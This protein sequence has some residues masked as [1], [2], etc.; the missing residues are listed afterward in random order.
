[1]I[2]IMLLEVFLLDLDA[3][4]WSHLR[5]EGGEEYKASP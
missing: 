5:R 4:I 1:M 3:S 2:S